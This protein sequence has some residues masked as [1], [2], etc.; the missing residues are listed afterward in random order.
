M[1]HSLRRFILSLLM[2]HCM[3]VAGM[4]VAAENPMVTQDRSG[5]PPYTNRLI[6]SANPYLLLHAH[7][8]VDWYLWGPEALAKAKKEN[9]PIVYDA[10]VAAAQ[11]RGRVLRGE[12]GA[13]VDRVRRWINSG[14]EEHW[15]VPQTRS[16]K[17]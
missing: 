16:E 2:L 9:K 14:F 5:Q 10:D 15:N 6:N 17:S 8:P 1:T 7:N 3:T 13:D 4:A 11:A 12:S